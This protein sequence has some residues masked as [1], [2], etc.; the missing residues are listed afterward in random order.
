MFK[1]DVVASWPAL[2]Q[3]CSGVN[4]EDLWDSDGSDAG[5]LRGPLHVRLWKRFFLVQGLWMRHRHT[6]RSS[7]GRVRQNHYL[8]A[9]DL[10]PKTKEQ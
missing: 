2:E 6:K 3:P 5:D 1:I 7:H 10:Q 8:L 9:K 4:G